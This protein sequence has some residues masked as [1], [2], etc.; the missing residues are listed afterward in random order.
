MDVR[1]MIGIIP[2]F[3]QGKLV[4]PCIRQ[5]TYHAS[6]IPFHKLINYFGLAI[7]L[8][9]VGSGILKTNTLQMEELLP[10]LVKEYHSF[11]TG[12]DVEITM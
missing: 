10:K 1:V 6:E 4:E 8:R 5:H 2:I 3:C 7:H 12:Y 11:V 9:M